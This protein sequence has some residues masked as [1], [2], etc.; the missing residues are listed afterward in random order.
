[1]SQNG[2]PHALGVRIQRDYKRESTAECTPDSTSYGT[3]T[4]LCMTGAET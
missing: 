3:T 1:M 4:V 2:C